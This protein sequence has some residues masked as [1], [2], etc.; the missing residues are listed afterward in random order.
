VSAKS[1]IVIGAGGHG[2]VVVSTLR[3]AGIDVIGVFD[4]D[5]E[6]WGGEILGV[7]VLGPVA[8][9]EGG[10]HL[11]VLGVGSNE[12]RKHLAERLGMRW[13][14]AVHPQAWI[15]PSVRLGE[16][17]VVFA[18]AVIQPDTVLGKHVIV[19]TG[20][21]IDHDCEIGDFVHVAP[22]T[23]MA[24]EVT[25]EN[26][27]FMGIGSSA[28]PGVRVGAWTTVGAGAAVVDDLPG[29]VTAVGVPARVLEREARG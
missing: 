19:N 2:K 14:T 18:G 24:G 7:P 20:A 28:I 13:A 22:G 3:A 8:D 9:A 6:K 26:G 5:E 27:A 11:V 21:L 16:G 12:A 15:H 10:D 17:S 1:V 23:R 4:D 25:L 29:G